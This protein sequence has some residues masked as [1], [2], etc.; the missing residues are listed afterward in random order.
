MVKY[1]FLIFMVLAGRPLLAQS[2]QD[3][4][5]P[6]PL[7]P[8][9]SLKNTTRTRPLK[10]PKVQVLKR[11]T[12][13]LVDSTLPATRRDR[14]I[15]AAGPFWQADSFL[16]TGHPY[17]S[18]T[19]PVRYGV[20]VRQWQGKEAIFYAV[21]G[22]LILFALIKNGFHRYLQDL[23]K[24]FFRSTL[25]QRQIREQLVQSPLPSLLLN[26]FFLVST[27]F[28]LTLI[29][30][31]AGLGTRIDFW[32]LFLYLEGALVVIY[33]A[34]FLSLK[35]IGWA[36]QVRD[37]ADAYIFI[38]FTTNKIMGMALLPFLIVLAFTTGVTSQ[39]AMNLG[40]TLIA[41]L[42]AYRYFLS[43]VS[44]HRQ[45]R[46]NLF[47]FVLYL[48]GFEIVPLLLINKLLFTFLS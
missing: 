27:G 9:D 37:A 38:V 5:G 24:I 3:S 22:L 8:A 33:G 19:H 15:V 10:P 7:L 48:C 14:I 1:L 4:L 6:V 20:S 16:Y 43:Y 46:V 45:I 40:L 31:H 44:I 12:A 32:M 28:F 35:F 2:T 47:H 34:K 41:L 29:L 21:I 13:G 30:Q 17:F 23:T 42:F 11:D 39:V 26:V 18:F 36:L 25:R